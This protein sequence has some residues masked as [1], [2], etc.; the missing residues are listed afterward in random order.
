[1]AA[2]AE[3]EHRREPRYSYVGIPLI[4]SAVNDSHVK[5]LGKKLHHA[6]AVDMSL[7]G[8][9]FDIDVEQPLLNGDKILVLVDMSEEFSHE[10]LMTEV[11]WCKELPSGQYQVGVV[12]DTV[13][14]PILK[15]AIPEI[16]FNAERTAP[17]EIEI[18]CPACKKTQPL[19]LL[20]INQY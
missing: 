10:E 2:N 20:S 18:L 16:N 6:A 1:M 9:A 4:Y 3:H 7:S 15:N 13:S 17:A 11:R 5:E 14:K 19:P 12:V 8:L